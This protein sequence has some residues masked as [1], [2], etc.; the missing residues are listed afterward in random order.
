MLQ[1]MAVGVGLGNRPDTWSALRPVACQHVAQLLKVVSNCL[2][3]DHGDRCAAV[4]MR[5]CA[6]GVGAGVAMHGCDLVP[7][8]VAGRS[9][10]RRVGQEC[11]SP[12]RYWC[13]PYN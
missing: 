10:A 13:C 1:R 8:L 11:V 4:L 9:E 3:I 2:V 7:A 6:V 12:C 5:V